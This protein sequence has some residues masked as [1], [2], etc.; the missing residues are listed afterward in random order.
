MDGGATRRG[1]G[2]PKGSGNRR[3]EDLRKY[4]GAMYGGMTPGQQLAA[5]AMVTPKE[6]REA[7]GDMT[8]AM[9][10]KA[11]RLA[12]ILD[13]KPADA[14]GMLQGSMKELMSYLHPKMAQLDVTSGGKSLA[15]PLLVIGDAP[16][17]MAGG[18][19]NDGLGEVL[20]LD[21]AGYGIVEEDQPLSLPLMDH[22]TEAKSQT[23]G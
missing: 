3:T 9:A 10:A 2:R 6:L 11:K 23:E 7:G 15:A 1:P 17:L 8:L 14:W 22:V 13:V 4:V 20:E 5:V 21:H 16:G 19:A 18:L 12:R